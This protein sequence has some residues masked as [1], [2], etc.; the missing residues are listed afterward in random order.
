MKVASVEKKE[1]EIAH[2]SKAII[3]RES[4]DQRSTKN[5]R[6]RKYSIHL[7][8]LIKVYD[9]HLLGYGFDLAIYVM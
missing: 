9:L 3:K 4:H 5:I 8:F 6:I 2:T 1:I 7:H